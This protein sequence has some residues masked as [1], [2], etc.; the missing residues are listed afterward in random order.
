MMSKL[1]FSKLF[2]FLGL[3]IV[4]Q[5]VNA[6]QN[7]LDSLLL[8][9]NKEKT[10][11]GKALLYSTISREYLFTNLDSAYYYINKGISLSKKLNFSKGLCRNYVSFS[12]YLNQ[13]GNQ[14]KA[15]EIG[16]EALKIAEENNEDFGR[17]MALGNLGVLYG[18]QSDF[19]KTIAYTKQTYELAKKNKTTNTIISSLINLAAGYLNGKQL[20]S[21]LYYNNL[22]LTEAYKLKDNIFLCAISSIFGNIHQNLNQNNIALEYYKQ[23]LNYA[24]I[25]KYKEGIIQNQLALSK[26]YKSIGKKD[27]SIYYAKK[28][29]ALASYNNNN[30][31]ILE[32]S[33]MIYMHFKEN[34]QTDS[35]LKYLEIINQVKDSLNNKEKIKQLQNI[36]ISEKIRQEDLA[37]LKQIQEQEKNDLIQYSLIAIFIICFIIITTIL[38]NSIVVNE[39][40]VKFLGIM[41]LLFFFEFINLVL[42]PYIIKITHHSPIFMLMIMV[43]IASLIIPTHHKIEK[44]IL[45]KMIERN[46]KIRIEH[47]KSIIE[48][49]E[50][51]KTS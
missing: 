22:A 4:S 29:L 34:R 28:S 45:P 39:R 47:A 15:L 46:K 17:M 31:V 9:L 10:D 32:S 38:S 41:G 20:D 35:A 12:S 24:E 7:I 2:C 26:L 8:K 40:I 51:E 23:G 33:K 37:E 3:I 48:A 13:I 49:N 16:I 36:T 25:S 1:Y 19:E 30:Y 42:H 27:S 11:T 43:G 14:T 21:S 6:Q 5:S 44:W 18:Y 50:T